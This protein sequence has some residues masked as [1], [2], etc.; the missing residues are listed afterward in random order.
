LWLFGL[1]GG[2]W[3]TRT[4]DERGQAKRGIRSALAARLA[5]LGMLGRE[6]QS[7]ADVTVLRRDPSH[8]H[9]EIDRRA[10]P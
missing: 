8:A 6:L 4:F 7:T 5:T 1:G 10:G 3:R 2:R 9:Q